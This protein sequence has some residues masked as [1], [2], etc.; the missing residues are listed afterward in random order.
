[1]VLK[2]II[3]PIKDF[4]HKDTEMHVFRALGILQR[5]VFL[6]GHQWRSRMKGGGMCVCN[7]EAAQGL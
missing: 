4:C 7:H 1:M 5:A 2:L 6:G 3:F